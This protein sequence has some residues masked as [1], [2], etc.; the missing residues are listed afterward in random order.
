MQI[1]ADFRQHLTQK[2]YTLIDRDIFW[3]LLLGLGVRLG[4]AVYLTPGFDEAYYTAYARHL[5][6]SYFD[7]PPL[8]AFTTGIGI[9]LT[10]IT[11]QFTMRLGT[12][13]LYTLTLYFFY[14]TGEHLFG[15]TTAKLGLIIASSIPI[16]TIAFGV[17]TSP[18]S[19]LMFFWSITL[20]LC[21]QEF[22]PKLST[23]LDNHE[24]AYIYQPTMRIVLIGLTTGLATLGKY[25]GFLLGACLVGFVLFTP[26]YWRIWRSSYLLGA[27]VVFVFAIAPIIIW[28]HQQDWVSIRFQATRAIPDGGI[29]IL[30]MLLVALVGCLY[31]FPSFGFP[32]W[33][34]NIKALVREIR[35]KHWHDRY[36]FIL[37][38]SAPIYLG[39]TLMGAYRQILPAWAM[40]GFFGAVLIMANQMA[41]FQSQRP[42]FVRN[43]LTISNLIILILVIVALLH[44][45][46]GIF[47]T[48]SK[49]A[50]LG[51]F[52]DPKDDAS[53]Q[54]YDLQQITKAF[55]NDPQLATALQQADFVFTNKMFTGGQ[56]AMAIEPLGKPV[57]CLDRDMRGFAYWAHPEQFLGQTALFIHD[58]LTAPPSLDYYRNY[59][60]A[61]EKLTDLDIDRGG[62]TIRRLTIYRAVSMT[63]VYPFPYGGSN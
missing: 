15:K 44:I 12:V 61:I 54:I 30:D 23:N 10:G 13:G 11:N 58:D 28:N 35:G 48:G 41:I 57:A 20:W 39:F 5:D 19:P 25:H 27:C 37:W 32:L 21:A 36:K 26:R 9:W 8:V 50:I 33:W 1:F 14:R 31:L 38:I 24:S 7:H 6:W 46:L 43:W 53:T 51:G 45:N 59:F 22:F 16:F 2:F 18:D 62:Q 4:I 52:I 42:K 17:L 34:I 55:T 56:I 47:Q 49:Y 29:R 40:P 3:I 63:Q 60:R